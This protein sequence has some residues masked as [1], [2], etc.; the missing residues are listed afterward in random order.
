MNLA[1][2]YAPRWALVVAVFC[3]HAALALVY[4]ALPPILVQVAAHFGG[5]ANGAMVAQFASSLPFFGIMLAGL[6]APVPIRTWG[7]RNVLVSA[8]ILFGLLGSAGA[9]LDEAWTLLFTRFMLGLAVG[10]MVT[11]CVTSVALNFEAV[12]RARMTGWLLAFGCLC[13]VILILVSGYVAAWYGWRAPFLLHG[14]ISLIFIVPVLLMG[15]GIPPV[16]PLERFSELSRLAPVMPVFAIAICLQG[17]AAIFLIQLAFLIGSAAFGTPEVISELFA[18]IGVAA[19]ATV[20]SYGRWLVH[21]APQSLASIGLTLLSGGFIAAAVADTYAVFAVCAILHGA[22]SALTQASLFN[23]AMLKTPPEQT[24]R[25]M[26]LMF[27]C[28]YL[29]AAVI[30]ALTAP[31]PIVLGIPNLFWILGTMTLIAVAVTGV[32]ARSRT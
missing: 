27:T 24:A 30:P 22:G 10:T 32:I 9:V 31:L 25:A 4:D 5:G 18:I 8:L 28:L 26:G 14:V 19:A 13:G 17:L 16:A 21:V 1:H 20:F 7:I 3:G 29:G 2:V 23:W 15:R 11:C 6:V 12:M